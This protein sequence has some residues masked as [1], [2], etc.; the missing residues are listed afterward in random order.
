[1]SGEETAQLAS[2]LRFGLYAHA[3]AVEFGRDPRVLALARLT[4]VDGRPFGAVTCK[5][6]SSRP[7]DLKSA[8]DLMG[9]EPT[10]CATRWTEPGASVPWC[11]WVIGY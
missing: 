10:P 6:G 3:A 11:S 5:D 2:L 4:E 7:F 1:M 9:T 8:L